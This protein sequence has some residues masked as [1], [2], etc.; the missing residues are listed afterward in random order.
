[1]EN[2]ANI[3][4]KQEQIIKEQGN[5]IVNLEKRMNQ[6]NVIIKG[7]SE[8]KEEDCVG[9]VKDFFTEKLKLTDQI[10]IANAYRLGH[11]KN[12]PLVVQLYSVRTKNKVFAYAKNLK[13]VKNERDHYYSIGN[14][15]PEELNEEKTRARD[16]V[17][18]NKDIP[19]AQR[20]TIKT[21]GGKVLIN[22]ETYRKQLEPITAR[23]ILEME[24]SEL[25]KINVVPAVT[26]QDMVE[27]G[28]AFRS[29]A[30][31]VRN[32]QE[33]RQIYNHLKLKYFKQT[34]VVVAY[35]LPGMN[36]AKG[37]DYHSDG[38]HGAGKVLLNVLLEKKKENTALFIVRQYGGTH[39]G[40]R[41]FEIYKLLALKALAA[42]ENDDDIARTSRLPRVPRTTSNR[43]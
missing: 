28:S 6:S 43:F 29:Y 21:K 30:A 18:L 35:N 41:R 32:I 37:K 1:M 22:N 15:L 27:E 8:Q 39:L 2:L 12:R 42:L 26:G 33:V 24:R 25:Q 4:V 9:V 7:I 36:V 13:G 23:E 10:Q 11:G 16:I 17:Y 40:A 5:K 3:V 14:H 20:P 38:E 19:E 34:H 31:S